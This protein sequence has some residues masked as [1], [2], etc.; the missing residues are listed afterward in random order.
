MAHSVD[1]VRNIAL[2]GHSGAGK[3]ALA[4]A[5]VFN[6]GQLNRLGRVEDGTTVSDHDPEEIER[7]I[8]IKASLLSGPWG[9]FHFNVIDTPGY[10]DFLP[11]TQSALRVADGSVVAVE[12]VS[13]IDVGTERVWKY[14]EEYNLPRIVFINKMDRPDVDLDRVMEQVRDR[15]GRQAVALQHPVSSG[16]GFHQVV[17]LVEMKLYSYIEG[18]SQATDLGDLESEVATMRE[19]LVEAIAETD[20]GLMEKYFSEGELSDEDIKAGLRKAI[21]SR[22]LF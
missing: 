3:T 18:K 19:Q 9:N 7:K 20:E 5:I 11:E 22:E 8:S 17:D 14:A 2:T 12:S 4:E 6:T 10:A 21:L 13:G 1:E 16:E 15:F